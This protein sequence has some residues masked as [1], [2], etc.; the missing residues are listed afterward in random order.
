MGP[1]S[2]TGEDRSPVARSK[3]TCG[4]PNITL[5]DQ[6]IKNVEK[7]RCL[8]SVLCSRG[9]RMHDAKEGRTERDE[10]TKT[11]GEELCVSTEEEEK[12]A[13]EN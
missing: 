2:F 12:D 3:W 5:T 13:Q 9:S 4:V 6:K 8:Q 10:S 7:F 11:H 1:R